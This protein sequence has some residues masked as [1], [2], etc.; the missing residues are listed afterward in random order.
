MVSLRNFCSWLKWAPSCFTHIC[1]MQFRHTKTCFRNCT[2]I[3]VTSLPR[4]DTPHDALL[5]SSGFIS[6]SDLHDWCVTN[7]PHTLQR[8]LKEGSHAQN[9]LNRV[10]KGQFLQFLIRYAKIL[11]DTSRMNAMSLMTQSYYDKIINYS[12][13]I[14]A[15]KLSL[16]YS[17]VCIL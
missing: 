15:K 2:S 11:S 8:G 12:C 6:F 5:F 3:T 14:G 4:E 17:S 9:S 16:Q 10:W 1:N 7:D 13:F